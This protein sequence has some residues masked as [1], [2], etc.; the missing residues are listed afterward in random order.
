MKFS[1]ETRFTPSPIVLQ[2]LITS[3]PGVGTK[4]RP[5]FERLLGPRVMDVLLHLPCDI[6]HRRFVNNVSQARTGEIITVIAEIT[7]H[8]PPPVRRKPYSV[9]CFDGQQFFDLVYFHAK[10]A[11]LQSILPLQTK[12]LI[13]GKLERYQ[14]R[15]KIT[16]PDYITHPDEQNHLS[17]AEAIYPLTAGITNKC[18]LKVMKSA[19]EHLPA[20]PEW[21][22][23]DKA[24]AW[25]KWEEAVRQVHHPKTQQD[26]E[27]KSLSRVRLAYDELLAHQLSIL[28]ARC[29]QRSRKQGVSIKGDDRL[30]A[31]IL[32]QLPFS[33]TAG[34]KQV[35][36]EI[37]MDMSSP[38]QMLRLVQGDV[39][40]G[41][42]LVALMAMAQA[43]EAGLQAAM[44]APTDILAR[45]H[46]EKLQP[47]CEKAGIRL[48]LLTGRDQGNRRAHILDDLQ[49][50]Q[51]DILVGTHAIIQEHVQ[52]AHLG[53]AVVDEQH[54][55]GV[56]QRLAL[57]EKGE[58]P[59]VLAMTATPIPRTLMLANY[60][61]MDFSIIRD[62]PA[63]RKPIETK[64][65]PLNRIEEVVTGLERALQTGAKI[66]WVC[67]LIDESEAMDM[68]AAV[69][70]Y[71]AL[72]Q[73]FPNRV[74]LVHGRLKPDE[75][76]TVMSQFIDGPIDI[77][78]ATT[79][80]EV[81][82][83]VPSAS[84]MIIE[85]AE[86][87]GL[88]QLHQLRGRIGRG[89][90]TAMCL[91]LYSFALTPAG[92]KRLE[93]MRQTNDG[94]LI[95]EEDLKLRGS[96]EILGTKQSGLPRFRIA[97]FTSNPDLYG[98]LLAMANKEAR[99]IC[100]D[101]PNLSTPRGQALQLL[102]Y[103]Y[104]RADAAKYSRSG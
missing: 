85:H 9:T 60:G 52:F 10:P 102:L 1:E 38:Q 41:K 80:I 54:R 103:L 66:Y 7:S 32:E 101:D 59:D 25:P 39:G 86:R 104:G 77:L 79:V 69:E 2:N 97:D 82:V 19:L 14:D 98:E 75:K 96:G 84:I 76:D 63:G 22:E 68:A 33:L 45:Q 99:R 16:H 3:L 47:I 89:N 70:R 13:S 36:A 12:K 72:S 78:I 61:D 95:S 20:L 5:L 37:E 93:I 6:V 18:I 55:F 57:T 51:I 40:S 35:I 58:R 24:R 29:H 62:K 28:L 50:H 74:G 83:D 64:V 34:Q 73:K 88:S 67:P 81:G 26:L 27:P 87:F 90:Q 23:E 100:Q 56:E 15:W 17:G 65:I 8:N 46:A 11:Y 48:M 31:R 30:K 94:F 44:L 49:N 43:V 42:T 92:R 91:L 53:L 4:R 21:L 71:E